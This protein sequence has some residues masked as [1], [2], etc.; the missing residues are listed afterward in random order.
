MQDINAL[1]DLTLEIEGLLRVLE[2]RADGRVRELVQQ[3]ADALAMALDSMATADSFEIDSDFSVNIVEFD[4]E[5]DSADE[6]AAMSENAYNVPTTVVDAPAPAADA[7]AAAEAPAAAGDAA[8]AADAQA[9]DAN[10]TRVVESVPTMP[11]AR[12]KSADE[13]EEPRSAPVTPSA[14]KS[15]ITFNEKYRFVRELFNNQHALM[16][17]VVAKV[18]SMNSLAEA[19]DYI[20]NELKLQEDNPVV[21]EFLEV[22]NRYFNSR[23]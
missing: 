12:D 18:T 14:P 10:A 5:I 20:L 9:I 23:T 16:A 19:H 6:N 1:L 13:A 7:P 22:V 17:D 4:D 8:P 11:V 21:I 3:K 2:V 15:F